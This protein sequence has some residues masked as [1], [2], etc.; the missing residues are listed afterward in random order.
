MKKLN[1][2]FLSMVLLSMAF[3]GCNKNDNNIDKDT[4][5]DYDL[6]QFVIAATPLATDGVADYLLTVDSLSG[7]SVSLLGNGI[8]QD[9]TYRYYVTNDDKFF[10]LLYGQGNPGAVTAYELNNEGELTELTDFQSETVAAFGNVD[11]DILM[12]DIPRGGDRMATW[13]RLSTESLTFVDQGQIDVFD[14]AANGEQAYFTDVTEVGDYVFAPYMSLKMCCN[15]GWGTKYADSAWIAVYNYPEMTLKTVIKDDRT[16]FIGKYFTSGLEETEN[17]D[18]Y[19]FSGSVANNNGEFTSTKPSAVTRIKSGTLAFDQSYFFNLKEASGGYYWTGK[20]YA[21]N[22][23]FVVNMHPVSK[24][25]AY[26]NG[27]KIAVINVV[28]KTFKWVTG[29]PDVADITLFSENNL[30]S[31]DGSTVYMGVTTKTGSHIYSIDIASATATQGIEVE[32][33]KITAISK[34]EVDKNEQ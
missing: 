29:L 16:S 9:G 5:E 32:G 33:G 13:Y 6:E 18:V 21:G 30:T 17:G 27:K 26:V 23:N 15:D 34:L 3:V 8:E 1:L 31:E 24:K 14:L 10:S 4:P 7:G 25:Q 2:Y 28:N 12:V 11:D 20:T 22:G 19:A